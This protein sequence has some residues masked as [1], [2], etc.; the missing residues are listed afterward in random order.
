MKQPEQLFRF[1]VD[2]LIAWQNKRNM[3]LTLLTPELYDELKQENYKYFVYKRA[4]ENRNMG[5]YEPVKE[6]PNHFVIS[7]RSIEDETIK[8]LLKE[9]QMLIDY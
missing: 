9:Q 5:V 2:Q 7:L 6:L 8:A 3:K 4:K 1:Q